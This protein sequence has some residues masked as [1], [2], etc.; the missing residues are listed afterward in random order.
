M[1]PRWRLNQQI[2]LRRC[3]SRGGGIRR[4][5]RLP[6]PRIPLFIEVDNGD[7]AHRVAI[8]NPPGGDDIGRYEDS[9][10]GEAEAV[11]NLD[12]L[13]ERSHEAG[14]GWS[15]CR[16]DRQRARARSLSVIITRQPKRY[17]LTDLGGARELRERD[18]P[19]DALGHDEVEQRPGL[20]DVVDDAIDLLYDVV[21]GSIGPRLIFPRKSGR[22]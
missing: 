5:D 16:R 4:P 7:A 2:E 15:R 21:R 18:R 10:S 1:A 19:I 6:A 13:A 17:R 9:S 11:S 14:G 3:V 12:V 8:G 22:G 20:V